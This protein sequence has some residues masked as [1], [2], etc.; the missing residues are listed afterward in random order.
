MKKFQTLSLKLIISII[1]CL[2]SN[3]AIASS[4][5]MILESRDIPGM[6]DCIA[7]LE[8]NGVR[9]V[10]VFPPCVV[11]GD[12]SSA[13]AFSASLCENSASGVGAGS[14]PALYQDKVPDDVIQSI[15]PASAI[16]IMVWNAQF[17][18]PTTK[19]P[20]LSTEELPPPANDCRILKKQSS[21]TSAPYLNA[22][23]YGGEF[24]DTSSYM[25]G[26]IAV[27]IILPESLGNTENWTTDEVNKVISEI[28]T[29]MDWW[30]SI[31]PDSRL[32]FYYDIHTPFTD[33]KSVKISSEPINTSNEETWIKQVMNTLGYTES[34]KDYF[35]YVFDYNNDIRDMFGTHWAFTIFVADSSNDTNGCFPDNGFAYAYMGGPFIVMTYDNGNY[36]IDHMDSVCAHEAGHIFYALDEY[37]GA[38]SKTERSGYLNV[39]NS[40][41]ESNPASV[42]CIMKGLTSPFANHQVCYYTLGQL[43]LW[44]TDNDHIIDVLD[45]PPQIFLSPYSPDP[46]SNQNPIYIGHAQVTAVPNKNPQ[47]QPPIN[48]ITINTISNIQYRINTDPWLS[49]TASDGVFDEPEEDFTFTLSRLQNGT[50]TFGVRAIDSVGNISNYATDLLTIETYNHAPGSFSLISPADTFVIG[51]LKPE[52]DWE[53][54]I[55]MDPDDVVSYTLWYAKDI[56]FTARTEVSGLSM[57]KY[58][59]TVDLDD[60]ST[61]YW[62]VCAVDKSGNRTWSRQTRSFSTKKI[63]ITIE[64]TLSCSANEIPTTPVVGD[65]NNDGCPEI[66]FGGIPTQDSFTSSHLYVFKKYAN[67][68]IEVVWC[69]S[70]NGACLGVSLGDLN[71][72][73]KPEIAAYTYNQALNS[74]TLSAINPDASI[75]WATPIP[76]RTPFHPDNLYQRDSNLGDVNGDGCA[77][78]V[79]NACDGSLWVISGKDGKEIWHKE[80]SGNWTGY[81]GKTAVVDLDN[82]GKSEVIIATTSHLGVYR[83]DGSLWW[84]TEGCDFA[85]ADLD[86][87]KKPEIVII[88]YVGSVRAYRYN[89]RAFWSQKYSLDAAVPAIADIDGDGKPEIILP[90]ENKYICSLNG[91]DGSLL[92]KTEN[93]N[94]GI[95]ENGDMVITDLNDDGL[96]EI[97]GMSQEKAIVLID[98]KTGKVIVNL[99]INID[100]ASMSPVVADVDNDGHAEILVPSGAGTDAEYKGKL[101][102]LGCDTLWKGCR[103]VWNQ[104]SYYMTNIDAEL[105]PTTD[106]S[107]WLTHNTWRAQLPEFIDS[108]RGVVIGM[109]TDAQ[110]L[111]VSGAKVQS[112]LNGVVNGSAISK[113]DGTYKIILLVPGDYTVSASSD[114]FFPA[115]R[116][117][118]LIVLG[119]IT[120][121]IDF[122]LKKMPDEAFS[123]SVLP[124]TYSISILE[125]H[126][127][128]A[129]VIDKNGKKVADGTV[130]NW[131]TNSGMVNPAISYTINGIATS[132]YTAPALSGIATITAI[133]SSTLMP[134]DSSQIVIGVGTL[135]RL[136][137]LPRQAIVRAGGTCSFTAQA[138][139][140]S[141]Q[142]IPDME[143]RWATAAGMGSLS[144]AMGTSN[145]FAVGGQLGTETIMVNCVISL[146]DGNLESRIQNRES[147]ICLSSIRDSRFAIRDSPASMT[148]TAEV[149]I[150]SADL[151][152]IVITPGTSTVEVGNSTG[153]TAAGYDQ[154]NHLLPD[155][156]YNWATSM[157]FGS[158][159][160]SVASS[161]RFIAG[162]VPG[163][164]TINAS[165][166]TITASAAITI[167]PGRLHHIV[168]EPNVTG[169]QALSQQ[170]FCARGYDQYS[171]CLTGILFDWTIDDRL[172]D[173]SPLHGTQTTLTAGEFIL[174]GRIIASSNGISGKA[175]VTI[176][177]GNLGYF[178]FERI[179]NQQAG[180]EFAITITAMDKG[181]N[182]INN[183]GGIA[184]LND[185]INTTYPLAG[186]VSGTWTGTISITKAARG[187]TIQAEEQNGKIVG[188]SN[189]FDVLPAKV[190]WIEVIPNYQEVMVDKTAFATARAYDQYN[191]R[192]TDALFDWMIAPASGSINR[193]TGIFTA[194]TRLGTVSLIASSNNRY[195]TATIRIIPGILDHFDFDN[196]SHK[197]AGKEFPI[198]IIAHDRYH[199]LIDTFCDSA[200]ITDSTGSIMPQRTGTFTNGLWNGTVTI[201]NL[202]LGLKITANYSGRCGTS[203][204]FSALV[205]DDIGISTNGSI[206]V[207]LDKGALNGTDYYPLITPDASSI[208]IERANKEFHQYPWVKQMMTMGINVLDGDNKPLTAGFGAPATM[209]VS[210][211]H[212]TGSLDV[213]SIRL[214]Q[215]D[216]EV[217][218][219]LSVSLPGVL[220]PQFDPISCQIWFAIP[221][222]GTYTLTISEAQ[223][224]LDSLMVYP[225]PFRQALGDT[226]IIF[227]GLTG[228]AVIRIYDLAG[229]LIREQKHVSIEW[230]WPVIDEGISSGIYFFVV[231]DNEERKRVGR[232]VII[233]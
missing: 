225:V 216:G 89:G 139:D 120:N 119:S 26:K 140:R 215:L 208:H 9:V 217:W 36:G 19:A 43:G 184:I 103:K 150:I 112:S 130:V 210:Y 16:G 31:Q 137:L 87:D 197:I 173:I 110:G 218:K 182:I 51:V 81:C 102:V 95:W 212:S 178:R 8:A 148:A 111:P 171:N 177:P 42:P 191:N 2:L 50:Y 18:P 25:A 12:F 157:Q 72:D 5:L 38:S 143:Y 76:N 64:A 180:N 47:E 59:P 93:L 41:H 233:R 189:S 142:E 14:K 170:V 15:P 172:G 221:G 24:Y 32:S 7:R 98:A 74:G 115:S 179:G 198:R 73:G 141:W 84:E 146:P 88:G 21:L 213:K 227:K 117:N 181:G 30:A 123:V 136:E 159:A 96:M 44:D 219:H 124:G 90:V 209:S 75:R 39:I 57:S 138:Y 48:D 232:I 145:T 201:N 99:D 70:T 20:I 206:T 34:G 23:P 49:A 226:H 158:V 185:T 231:I 220:P 46:T 78:V 135:Y 100:F 126:I 11:I 122:C 118:V 200:D 80:F 77:D 58:I 86:G 22:P 187:M 10:H 107:P 132:T 134:R 163:T 176:T 174:D 175:T 108:N 153:F 33:T 116:T 91:E 85:I 105:L 129:E 152:H 199:N 27:G 35:Y 222:P 156:K 52:F 165:L 204:Q 196:I 104:I 160:I 168:I 190:S 193:A 83:H 28:Q 202:R 195:A 224:N 166:G 37:S 71:N 40:N 121:H 192:V 183:Y 205:D 29:A 45:S 131:Q 144:Q 230:R 162:T 188:I 62:K 194:G 211:S 67:N 54:A 55:D 128:T 79:I 56:D 106:L 229:D 125:T 147:R 164:T 61:Y 4:G 3:I 17:I 92:W 66:V 161:T 169:V 228:D 69:K 203:N 1:F 113:P 151:H 167:I 63:T 101:I 6:R 60:N 82:D 133:A 207:Q 94:M 186:F 155:I 109:I 127:W 65:I 97:A 114:G 13:S 154:Y 68:S 149:T 223:G 214:Y 53:D